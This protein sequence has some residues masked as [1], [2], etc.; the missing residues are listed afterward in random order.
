MKEALR[1]WNIRRARRRNDK[2][3]NDYLFLDTQK[4]FLDTLSSSVA[5]VWGGKADL[6]VSGR[7]FR[8]PGVSSVCGKTCH[9]MFVMMDPSLEVDAVV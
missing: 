1:S 6:S 9:D 8:I 5:S 3:P 7:P 4:D 2:E